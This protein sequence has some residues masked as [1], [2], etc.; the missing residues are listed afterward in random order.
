MNI[1]VLNKL[2]AANNDE[3]EARVK[4]GK[5]LE[6]FAWTLIEDHAGMPGVRPIAAAELYRPDLV[7][8]A[9]AYEAAEAQ[10]A[11]EQIDAS[12]TSGTCG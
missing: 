12:P 4:F 5:A 1:T 11:K 9:E 10:K 6:E 3:V 8:E 2:I 7:A